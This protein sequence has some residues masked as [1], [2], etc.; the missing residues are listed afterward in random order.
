MK[1]EENKMRYKKETILVVGII[2]VLLPFITG[3]ID[4]RTPGFEPGY[5]NSKPVSGEGFMDYNIPGFAQKAWQST[6]QL[7]ITLIHARGRREGRPMIGAGIILDL[8]E[9][10]QEALIVTVNH[11][12]NGRKNRKFKFEVRFPGE[13]KNKSGEEKYYTARRT[14]IILTQANK[15]LVYLKVKYPKKALPTAAPLRVIDNERAVP[16]SLMTIGF[17]FLQLRQLEKWNTPV[18]ENYKKLIKRFSRGNLIGKGLSRNKVYILAH[19]A[20]MLK[21]NSGGPLVDQDGNV[22]GINLGMFHLN[23]KGNTGASN[24]VYTS[25][26]ANRFYYAISASEVV[27]DIE[28]IRNHKLW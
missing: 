16:E 26:S 24:S 2:L 19:N 15:D 8:D 21:G 10:K 23:T 25:G 3:T 12:N 5:K 18:P 6:V 20:D 14:A 13:P 27:E 22:V 1:K 17:P 4:A 7:R 28:H 9:Q 11:Y